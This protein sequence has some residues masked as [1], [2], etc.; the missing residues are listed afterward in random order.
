MKFTAEE[1][2]EL[3]HR[4]GGRFRVDNSESAF[5]F[6]KSL[7]QSH[8]ENFPVASFLIK[9]EW[10]KYIFSVYAFARIADDIADEILQ[11]P[12]DERIKMLDNLEELI[13][14]TDYQKISNPI[15]KALLITMQEKKIPPK[16]FQKLLTAYI[17]DIKFQQAETFSDLLDYCKYSAEP[18]GELVLRITDNYN[19]RN[20]VLSDKICSALQL[21]NFWQDFSVD[22]KNSRVF[23]PKEYLTKYELE[24]KGLFERK[25]TH[26]LIS[27]LNELYDRTELL[28]NEGA[29]LVNYLK[30]LRIKLEI[31]ATVLGG[32]SILRKIKDLQAN[33]LDKRPKLSKKDFFMI[34]MK[35]IF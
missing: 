33:I 18:I 19:E 8:Y 7:A 14:N 24:V 10:R 5:E 3:T 21:I 4:D 12:Q 20:I 15:L 25:K 26:N 30:N 6:C 11:V 29:E 31:K 32:L 2:E 9:K 22:L 16:P 27:C 17:M 1:L 35:I 34:F 23:I 28:L 13:Q